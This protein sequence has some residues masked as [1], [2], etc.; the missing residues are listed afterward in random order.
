MRSAAS[1]SFANHDWLTLSYTTIVVGVLPPG[2]PPLPDG[3][4]DSSSLGAGG[5][6]FF[7]D[8]GFGGDFAVAG[9]D[10]VVVEGAGGGLALATGEGGGLALA[11]LHAEAAH[12]TVFFAPLTCGHV[13]Q[14][15]AAAVI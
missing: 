10:F 13:P 14:F 15:F 12:A 9:G 1:S 4:G 8:A 11:P 7:T 2:S 3:R 5:G 6:D